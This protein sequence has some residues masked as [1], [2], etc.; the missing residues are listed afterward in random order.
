LQIADSMSRD[1]SAL[2]AGDEIR[3]AKSNRKIGLIALAALALSALGGS[4]YWIGREYAGFESAVVR[5][6]AIACVVFFG[7]GAVYA[8][9]RLF[10]DAPGVVISAAGILDNSSGVAVGLIKWS[11]IKDFRVTEMMTQQFLTIDVRTPE[12]Y[13]ERGNVI[14]RFFRRMNAQFYGSPVQIALNS[15]DASL[16]ELRSAIEQGLESYRRR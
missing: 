16:D 3:I 7:G 8:I 4:L 15:L 12:A 9:R 14:Q 2:R 6:A 5:M 1:P 13:I 10:D 11:D